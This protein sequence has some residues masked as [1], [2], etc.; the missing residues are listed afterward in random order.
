MSL[1]ATNRYMNFGPFSFAGITLTGVTDFGVQT[2]ISVKKEGSDGDPGPTVMVQDFYD[3]MFT[4]TTLNALA[5]QALIGG[6]RGVLIATLLDAY[7]KALTGGGAKVLTTNSGTLI[8][9]APVTA[10]YR[11]YASRQL[12]FQTV[13]LDPATPPYAFTAA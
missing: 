4:V 2:G 1:L 5:L 7:N 10:R 3:P 12:T 6:A 13:W 8:A 9:D 11:E